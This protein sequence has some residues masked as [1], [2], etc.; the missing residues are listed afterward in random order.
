MY[1]FIFLKIQFN[2]ISVSST[3]NFLLMKESLQIYL[4][5]IELRFVNLIVCPL[6]MDPRTIRIK[7]TDKE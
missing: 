4:L 1:K 2:Y 7:M 5:E 3:D 6:H